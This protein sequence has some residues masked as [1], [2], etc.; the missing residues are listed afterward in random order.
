M[1]RVVFRSV[2]RLACALAMP[3]VVGIADACQGHDSELATA[4]RRITAA[5]ASATASTGPTAAV[6]LSTASAAL[7]QTGTTAWTLAKTG[8]VDATS[9]TV[10]WTI[11]ATKGTTTAGQLVVSGLIAVTNTGAAGGT[12]GNVVVTLQQKVRRGVDEPFGRC[13]RRHARRRGDHGAHR[14]Q[15]ELGES[16]DHHGEH[17]LGLAPVPGCSRQYAL[18][19]RARA[20]DRAG[21]NGDAPL[22]R[23]LR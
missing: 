4:P 11:T 20:D 15:G 12:I 22:Q 2:A 19:P 17:R 3:A 23:A 8:A 9:K 16:G 7:T 21:S 10:T 5:D 18:R 6:T 1:S 13:R 14:S